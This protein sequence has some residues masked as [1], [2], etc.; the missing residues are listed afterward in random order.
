MSRDF[1]LCNPL[2]TQYIGFSRTRLKRLILRRRKL[3]VLLF[4]L[5]NFII[6][7]NY[8]LLHVLF[9]DSSLGA[10]GPTNSYNSLFQL[11][12]EIPMT[13]PQEDI[14]I[15]PKFTCRVWWKQAIRL[16][17]DRGYIKCD[18]VQALENECKAYAVTNDRSQEENKHYIYLVS[19][20]SRSQV[21]QMS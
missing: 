17:S 12:K 19:K 8:N 14:G 1:T 18:N 13:I 21:S 4:K 5:V 11:L 7:P 15:E 20:N 9:T 16:L 6:K 2:E 3:H 10:L